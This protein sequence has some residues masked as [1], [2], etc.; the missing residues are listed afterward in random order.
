MQPWNLTAKE[1]FE[2]QPWIH[3]EIEGLQRASGRGCQC[4]CDH[5]LL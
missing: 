3:G 5:M 2:S 4:I 1:R